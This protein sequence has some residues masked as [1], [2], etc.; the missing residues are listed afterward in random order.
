MRKGLFI[1]AILFAAAWPREASAQNVLADTLRLRGGPCTQR[2]GSGSPEGVVAAKV[3]DTYRDGD[4]GEVYQK[5]LGAA[6]TDTGW[7]RLVGPSAATCTTFA[8]CVAASLETDFLS[9]TM[10]LRTD[11]GV[12]FRVALDARGARLDSYNG[13]GWAPLKLSG[14]PTRV[15]GGGFHVGASDILDPG[16]GNA[17]I[18]GFIGKPGYVSQTTGWRIDG[19]GAADFRYLYADELHARKFIA[20]LEQALA[21]LQ[22]IAKSVGQIGAVFTVPAPGSISTLTMKDLPSAENMAIFESG[23]YVWIRQFSRED[24]SL[25]ITNAF[26]TVTG[27]TDLEDGL[28]SWQFTRL[29]TNGGAMATGA[30]IEIDSIVLDVGVPGNGW[31]ETNAIDGIYG[32]NSPYT[33]VVTWSGDSPISGNQTLR[34]R[35]GNLRGITGVTGEFGL[36]AGTYAATNG[37]YLRASNEAFELH[38]IDLKMWNGTTNVFHMERLTPYFSMGSPAPTSFTSGNGCW[39][40]MDAG[41]FKWRCGNISGGEQYI[42]WNGTQLTVA[43]NIVVTGTS[44]DAA[45]VVGV[46]GDTVV[47]GAARGLLGIDSDGNPTLP[48]TATPSGSGLFL[49]SDFMGYYASGA[50]KTFM[51]SSGHFYLGGTS[52]ALQWNG[53]TLT[54]S[55]TLTGNGSGITSITGGNITTGSVTS[56]QIAANTITAADIAASTITSTQIAA[57]T[58]TASDIAA[59]TITGAKIAAGTITGTNIQ[60]GSI[61]ATEINVSSLSALSANLGTVTAGSLS[62]VTA[63]FGGG[64]GDVTLDEDGVTFA[65]GTGSPN[66]VKWDDGT[67]MQ[68]SSDFASWVASSSIS[69]TGGG[70]ISLYATTIQLRSS[71]GTTDSNRYPMVMEFVGVGDWA[72]VDLKTNGAHGTLCSAGQFV[73]DITVERG[74][75]ISAG[76]AFPA[77]APDAAEI[78]ALRLEVSELR[79]LVASLLSP[80]VPAARAQR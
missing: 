79:A 57:G 68:S 36:I 59:S 24:G 62:G 46:D 11:P 29:V 58:I 66:R 73:S 39:S 55:A 7:F 53:T 72:K 33:Q 5:I 20:D 18:D 56:T 47:S 37:Q 65:N 8:G 54:I 23:D 78:A 63:V 6:G 1:I 16:L 34:T 9:W 2:A 80:S 26:G 45:T 21:G 49:G 76:C 10:K 28:Q 17:Q 15:K 43:G 30:E 13:A 44:I 70:T 64:G 48:A 42:S 60:A 12:Q 50:W 35:L 71:F 75:V 41:V 32:I 74:I 3:C 69:L 77:P 51:N 19:L 22:I 67:Y 27:Y 61:S 25:S 38:G 31:V 52:G 40:G 4:T 14:G